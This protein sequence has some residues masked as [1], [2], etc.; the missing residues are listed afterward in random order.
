MRDYKDE[1][2][3]SRIEEPREPIGGRG[4]LFWIVAFFAS[5]YLWETF[6]RWVMS[7]P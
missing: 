7:C 2:M 4:A 3:D 1:T 5:A 6:L